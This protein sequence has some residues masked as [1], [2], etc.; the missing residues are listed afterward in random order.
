MDMLMRSEAAVET[1]ANAFL[2]GN[3]NLE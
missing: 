2:Q 3:Y 1:I